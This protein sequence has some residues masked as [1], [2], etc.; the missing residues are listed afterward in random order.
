MT[1]IVESEPQFRSLTE[2][3]VL[4]AL[5]DPD[6]AN[7]IACEI[8]RL[9]AAYTPYTSYFRR[10]H[11]ERGGHI[12]ADILRVKPRWPIEAVAMRL[13]HAGNPRVSCATCSPITLRAPIHLLSDSSASAAASASSRF[14]K[15]RQEAA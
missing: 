2:D 3:A 10:K 7:P 4:A 14:A 9:V 13:H 11:V 1:E 12:Q 15:S 5:N 8:I 6:A